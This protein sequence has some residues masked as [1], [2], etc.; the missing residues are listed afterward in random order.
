[1][2]EIEGSVPCTG[3]DQINVTNTLTLGDSN[4]EIDL[5]YEPVTGTEY[6][7][8][9]AGNIIG[10]FEQGIG[11]VT[12]TFNSNTYFFH[13]QYHPDKVVLLTTGIYAV[14]VGKWALLLSLVL[15][16]AF[17]LYRYRVLWT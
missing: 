7:I 15:I 6:T 4:L 10:E 13:I 2:V 5:D 16:A 17:L 8:F 14:P 11:P 3:Y 1:M 9:T 12:A